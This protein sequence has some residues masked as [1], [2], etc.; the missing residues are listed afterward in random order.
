M[1]DRVVE[2]TAT[3][4]NKEK[5]FKWI[6]DSLWNNIECTDIRIMGVPEGEERKGKK[7][8]EEII[9]EDFPDMGEETLKLRKRRESHT[10]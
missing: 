8:L 1:E 7:T 9:V 6:E 4:K 5:R 3:E 2:I 10:G